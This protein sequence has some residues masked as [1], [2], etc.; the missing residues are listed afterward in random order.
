LWIYENG[1]GRKRY[2]VTT[3][4]GAKIQPYFDVP[5]PN[6]QNL[7]VFR[8]QGEEI[9]PGIIRIWIGTSTARELE[10][11]VGSLT[12]ERLMEVIASAASSPDASANVASP[13]REQAVAIKLISD[14]Y[15]LLVA[16]FPG[17]VSDEHLAQLLVE[18]LR[19]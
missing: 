9:S 16:T 18:R 8:V 7:Y 3:V 11:L 6:D 2:S 12:P 5:P 4:A 15:R 10:Y 17:A 19:K 14:S 1:T 13:T